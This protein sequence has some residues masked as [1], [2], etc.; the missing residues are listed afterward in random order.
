MLFAATVLLGLVHCVASITRPMSGEIPLSREPY[1]RAWI[2]SN[3]CIKPRTVTFEMDS[4]VQSE[5]I[6]LRLSGGGMNFGNKIVDGLIVSARVKCAAAWMKIIR[7]ATA[8]NQ[9]VPRFGFPTPRSENILFAIFGAGILG[10]HACALLF[11]KINT[12]P[13]SPT[14]LFLTIPFTYA[15]VLQVAHMTLVS[16]YEQAVYQNLILA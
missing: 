9:V 14:W 5:V 11:D 10:V 4:Y 1:H 8:E 15:T 7:K 12:I 13:T 16:F 6:V 2:G 3:I